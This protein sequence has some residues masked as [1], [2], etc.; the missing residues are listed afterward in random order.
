MKDKRKNIKNAYSTKLLVI[1]AIMIL[2]TLVSISF[3]SKNKLNKFSKIALKNDAETTFQNS[4]NNNLNQILLSLNQN[5]TLTDDSGIVTAINTTKISTGTGPFDAT[6]GA[7]NDTSADDNI[8][9]S[10]DQV[11]YD[12]YVRAGGYGTK[13]TGKRNWSG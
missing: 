7:G 13:I 10:F 12:K 9:R 11:T 3:V 2:L 8:V 6:E 4:I 5:G 1:V